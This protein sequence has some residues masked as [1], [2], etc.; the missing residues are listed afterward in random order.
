VFDAAHIVKHINGQQSEE[1]ARMGIE[2]A[3]A[4]LEGGAA[5]GEVADRHSDC[6]GKGS[7]LGQFN[8]GS[9]VEEFE[10]AIRDLEPGQ[11]TGIFR[12]PFGFHIAELRSKVPAGPVE[13]EE[14][15][16]DIRGVLT[17]IREH[18]EYLRVVGEIRSRAT[19]LWISEAETPRRND[20]HE[21]AVASQ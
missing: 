18:Q 1:Q 12:T 16:E 17:R 20:E 3:L 14:V 8:A 5:F 19:I 21:E 7:D 13:F 2:A 4:E 15:R 11:R 10:D 6:K 9:M